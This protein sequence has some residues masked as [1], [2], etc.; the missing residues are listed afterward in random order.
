MKV[1]G[2]TAGETGAERGGNHGEGRE[3]GGP[4]VARTSTGTPCYVYMAPDES[5]V[6]RG[7]LRIR[8]RY[9]EKLPAY[10]KCTG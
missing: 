8:G 4:K 5:T 1:S 10:R 9:L 7:I 3:N 2:S 6:I